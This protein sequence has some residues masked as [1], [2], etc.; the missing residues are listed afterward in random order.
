M[1]KMI[2]QF[3]TVVLKQKP[4]S[5]VTCKYPDIGKESK[6]MQAYIKIS[7]QLHMMGRE[8]DGKKIK[9]HFDPNDYV[10]RAQF[11]TIL[12]RMLRDG[13]YNTKDSIGWYKLHLQALKKKSIMTK[14]DQPFIDE[15]R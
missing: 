3:A 13:K 10:D 11:G 14:I 2:S 5:K 7:C 15:L 9:K 6:E 1:A 4:D 12:S 8:S